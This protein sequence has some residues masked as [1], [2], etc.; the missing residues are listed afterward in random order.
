MI[1]Q[2]PADLSWF[3]RRQCLMLDSQDAQY[4]EQQSL[5]ELHERL[6]ATSRVVGKLAAQ[7]RELQ[8]NLTV[9]Q[10]MEQQLGIQGRDESPS[11]QRDR[12]DC[13]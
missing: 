6:G 1:D 9:Q 8:D 7:L 3:P 11:S 4:D 10:R 12:A 5:A 13:A 2:D